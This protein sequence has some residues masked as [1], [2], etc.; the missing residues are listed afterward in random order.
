VPDY[1]TAHL[2]LSC[3]QKFSK[4]LTRLLVDYFNRDARISSGKGIVMRSVFALVVA[5]GFAC[6]CLVNPSESSAQIPGF[7]QAKQ[8]LAKA[9]QGFQKGIGIAAQNAPPQAQQGLAQAQQ[10]FQ[11]GLGQAM[12]ALANAQQQAVQGMN[13]AQIGKAMAQQAGPPA[14]I[15][16]GGPPAGIGGIGKGGP[17]AGIGG[18]GKGGPPAGIGKGK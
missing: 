3:R 6:I 2:I 1:C 11:Q 10:G 13:Q 12:Q 17:P 9:Q 7:A 8:G 18:I 5:I 14:G 4:Q 16:K 15:G